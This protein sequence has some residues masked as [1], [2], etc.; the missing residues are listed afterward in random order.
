[1][2]YG[3][4][5]GTAEPYPTKL[6]LGMVIFPNFFGSDFS[7]FWGIKPYKTLMLCQLPLGYPISSFFKSPHF[8]IST[9]ELPISSKTRRLIISLSSCG[10]TGASTSNGEDEL[11]P[12]SHDQNGVGEIGFVQ[13]SF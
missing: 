2:I 9:K 1:L 4:K 3:G 6:Y 7:V 12:L 8:V 10:A 11:L 5:K 13:M